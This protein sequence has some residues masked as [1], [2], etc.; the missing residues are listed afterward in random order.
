MLLS[1]CYLLYEKRLN[2]ACLMRGVLRARMAPSRRS[3]D[4]AFS[5]REPS[6]AQPTADALRM[7]RYCKTCKEK[8]ESVMRAQLELK[9]AGQLSQ[10]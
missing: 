7:H 10:P 2:R 3:A 4:A 9:H 5:A 6:S 8:E 1:F